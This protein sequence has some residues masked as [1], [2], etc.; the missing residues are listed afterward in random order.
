MVQVTLTFDIRCLKY[1]SMCE[2]I[3]RRR[4]LMAWSPFSKPSSTIKNS[5]PP[6]RPA[7]PLSPTA[8]VIIR[9]TLTS[10]VSPNIW[11]NVSLIVLKLSRSI[12]TKVTSMPVSLAFSSASIAYFLI[13]PLLSIPVSG[14]RSARTDS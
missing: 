12:I 5:S 10:V 2:R 14:S 13:A 9:A 7:A 1:H 8:S 4:G 3:E 11:P 6:T